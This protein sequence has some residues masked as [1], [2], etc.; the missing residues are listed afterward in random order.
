MKFLQNIKLWVL[1]RRYTT[2]AIVIS[3]V[4][5]AGIIISRPPVKT[6]SEVANKPV[7][8]TIT[9]AEYSGTQDFSTVGTVRAFTEASVTSET[10]GRVVSVNALLGQT[11]PASFIVATLENASERAAV[12]QAEGAYEAALAAAAQGNISVS[13]ANTALVT[14]QNS[15]VSTVL[16]SY[17]TVSGVIRNSVDDFLL[18]SRLKSSRLKNRWSRNDYYNK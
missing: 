17:N 16:S 18:Q 2:G 10:G 8:T 5:I 11:V 12:L 3:V 13:E 9:A 1:K 15:A 7:V 6:E 4:A 14:A